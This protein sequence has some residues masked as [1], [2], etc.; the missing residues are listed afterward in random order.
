M[1]TCYQ[2]I[3]EISEPKIV[4]AVIK[5]LQTH[6]CWP[7]LCD[8]VVLLYQAES[9]VKQYTIRITEENW[10]N[11]PTPNTYNSEAAVITQHSS[12]GKNSC[13][14]HFDVWVK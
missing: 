10:N 5:N 9:K 11:G 3:T 6:C 4:T 13:H 7:T 2:K 14:E 1:N 8:T 12:Q